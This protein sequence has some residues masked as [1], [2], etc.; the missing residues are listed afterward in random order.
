M[1]GIF[2]YHCQAQAFGLSA[3]TSTPVQSPKRSQASENSHFGRDVDPHQ[4]PSA[5]PD[6]P[7]K[8]VNET[9]LVE[10]VVVNHVFG[11]AASLVTENQVA[12]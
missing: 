2:L 3:T 10:E 7:S 11:F 9:V 5:P 8:V 1:L 12:M 6:A 4:N